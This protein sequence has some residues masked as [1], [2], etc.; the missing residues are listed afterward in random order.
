MCSEL[1]KKQK[2][3]VLYVFRV[4]Q[5]NKIKKQHVFRVNQKNKIKKQHVFRVNQK[6]THVFRGNY[7][8]AS[9]KYCI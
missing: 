3:E 8:R 5:K 9:F 7:I 6:K 1:T 4:N 2:V